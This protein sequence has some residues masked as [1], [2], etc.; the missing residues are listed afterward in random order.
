MEGWY[1]SAYSR[2]LLWALHHRGI[3]LG[4]A[5][6]LFV[7]SLFV[8]A[9]R[10]GFDFM[11]KQ[12]TPM[13]MAVVRMPVGTSLDETNRVVSRLEEVAHSLPETL[14]SSTFIGLQKAT[15]QDV[16]FG[17]GAAGVHEAQFM[18]RLKDKLDRERSSEEIVEEIRSRMP[19]IPG[20]VFEFLDVGQMMMG[21]L[22]QTPVVIKIYGKDL[23][24]LRELGERV[25]AHVKDVPGLRDV[26]A[27]L[28]VGK[29]EVRIQVDREKASQMGLSVGQVAHTAKAAML[30]EVATVF[31]V[32][33]DEY[34]IRVRFQEQDRLSLEDVRNIPV[35]SPLGF[36]APL[37]QVAN[38]NH[39]GGPVKILREDQERKNMVTANTFG[40]DIATVVEEIKRRLASMKLPSGYFLEYGGA[41]EDMKESQ[42]DLLWALLIAVLLVYMVMAAQFESLRQPFII[43]FTVPLT[44][45]GA[46]LGL[47]AFGRS[48]SVPALMGII[49]LV[50][51]A[52]NNGIVL[53]DY[54][55]QLRARGRDGWSAILEGASVRI[56]PI[57]ITAL[58]TMLGTFPMAVSGSE[59]A[60]L[61][62]PMGIT[63]SFGLLSA[64]LLTLY[65]VPVVYSLVTGVRSPGKG[66]GH[67][68]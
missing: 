11:P 7:V 45:I 41:Y 50:G 33:G 62:S 18:L 1:R 59:G 23:E 48:M 28:E 56:R 54:V 52:V 30:G 67:D 2:S 16:A 14:Y 3:V 22:E 63:I 38:L 27:T 61:R 24:R 44:T 42:G 29:P 17:F 25:I 5:A 34:D 31:R 55:N 9:T 68:T 21:A 60:E 36:H 51:I 43:M 46:G 26:R 13:L 39:E 40:K 10:L 64:T 49:I 6:L 19:R 15:K 35:A 12:D 65:V 32:G 57:L 53:V 47:W 37:Y 66:K 58:T 8:M 4:S 20:A